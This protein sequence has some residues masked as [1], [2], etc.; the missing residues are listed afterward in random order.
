MIQILEVGAKGELLYHVFPKWYPFV[1]NLF[2][3]RK[4]G[5]IT[6]REG[7]YKNWTNGSVVDKI[8]NKL[9][10]EWVLPILQ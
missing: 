3:K 6:H 5:Y 4:T 1:C 10:P 2:M 7:V 9:I 8:H